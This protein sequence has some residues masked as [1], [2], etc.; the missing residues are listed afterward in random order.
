MYNIFTQ[1][2]FFQ[3]DE[4]KNTANQAKHGVSFIEAQAVFLDEHA[5]VSFDPDHS[6]T[7]ERFL[8]LGISNRLR[9]LIVSCCLGQRKSM[10]RIIS[11]RKANRHEENECWRMRS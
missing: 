1:P 4:R 10:I 9:V 7:Q 3:W 8:L 2:P 5:R 11:A 6:E